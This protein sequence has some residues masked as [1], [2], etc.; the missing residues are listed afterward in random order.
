M[1]AVSPLLP[2]LKRRKHLT[3]Q[4]FELDVIVFFGVQH[5][6]NFCFQM[7]ESLVLTVLSVVEASGEIVV[8]ATAKI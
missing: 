1:N 4:F 8:G 5:E 6:L 7:S 2:A 3:N